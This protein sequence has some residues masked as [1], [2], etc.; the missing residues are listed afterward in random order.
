MSVTIRLAKLGKRNAPTYKI[1]VA[2][3]R[4]KRNGRAI[5][6][7]GYYNPL[8][9]PEE[10]ELNKDKYDQWKANGAITSAA[11]EKLISGTYVFVP[12]DPKGGQAVAGEAE[13]KTNSVKEESEQPADELAPE[14]E[15]TKETEA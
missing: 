8:K 12:Y 6:V 1:V 14:A 11:V 3:T 2:N 5:D 10:F 13:T 4:D 15:E 9:T 7:L